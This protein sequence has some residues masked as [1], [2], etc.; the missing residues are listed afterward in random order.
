MVARDNAPRQ[1]ETIYYLRSGVKPA[2]VRFGG[3]ASAAASKPGE[4][5]RASTFAVLAN[6]Q[7]YIELD[8]A[9]CLP[10]RERV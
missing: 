10:A 4:I 3:I 9:R 8:L 1:L 7:V 2:E 6:S 5:G